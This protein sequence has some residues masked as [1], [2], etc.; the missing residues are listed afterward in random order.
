MAQPIAVSKAVHRS[1]GAAGINQ[2]LSEF[3]TEEMYR[4]ILSRLGEDPNRDGL[5]ATP[6]R[7]EKSMAFLTKGYDEDS[8]GILR[9]AL[10]DVDYDEM[11][12]VK[13]IEMFSLCEHHMLPFFGKVHV[14]Y[15]PKGKVVGLSKIPRLV[16]VFARRLQVQERLTRQIADAIQKVIEPQGVGV[17]IEARHLCMMMRGIEKQH[18]STVTSAMLGCFRQKETRSEFL[19]LVRQQGSEVL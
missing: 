19:A 8:T 15:I 7:V 17:V 1:A 10:F 12:I 2:G 6:V 4:E 18:S 5:L 9:G 13:D 3:S 16:E 11:V 14:A